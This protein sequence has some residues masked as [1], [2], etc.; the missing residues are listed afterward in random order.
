MTSS[1]MGEGLLTQARAILAEA[2]SLNSHGEWSLVVRRSQEIV[3]LALKAALRTAGLEVPKLHDV[4]TFLKDHRG[5]FP[6]D[7][8]A[9]LDDLVSISQRLRKERETAF[10]GDEEADVPPQA[11]YTE[12]HARA[13]LA[14]A[15]EVFDLCR[16]LVGSLGRDAG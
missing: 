1:E 10:Y 14:D 2:R 7:F 12:N 9:R 13:A 15:G 4:G 6:V 16:A 8:R 11:L 3:E 5:R